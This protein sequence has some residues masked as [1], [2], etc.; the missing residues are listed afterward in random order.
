MFVFESVSVYVRVCM[1]V[2]IYIYVCVCVYVL[3]C[4][5]Q[6]CICTHMYLHTYTMLYVIG[7][8]G[9]G[10]GASVSNAWIQGSGVMVSEFSGLRG[11]WT[12]QD[13]FMR[14]F[15]LPPVS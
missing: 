13:G 1:Y 5:N 12:V 7:F 10:F 11:C 8:Q 14:H 2:Y 4:F 9:A 3:L 6:G 15:P